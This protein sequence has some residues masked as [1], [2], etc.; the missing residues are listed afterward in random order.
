MKKFLSCLLIVS[1]VLSMNLGLFAEKAKGSLSLSGE[2]VIRSEN[3]EFI[4]EFLSGALN[5]IAAQ[6]KDPIVGSVGGEWAVIALNRGGRKDENWNN[7]Y[8][9]NLKSYLDVNSNNKLT[10]CERMILA[11]TSTGKDASKFYG[12]DLVSELKNKN[13]SGGYALEEQGINAVIY[14]L[15]ALDSGNYLPNEEG[16]ALRNWCI[17]YLLQHEKING[18]WDYTGE[19]TGDADVDMTGIA[20]QALAPYYKNNGYRFAEVKSSVETA[21]TALQEAQREDGSFGYGEWP[22]SSDSAAS[23]VMAL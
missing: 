5:Y 14:A 6:V 4:E 13:S 3:S 12:Y 7:I 21:V 9:N 18:G 2:S 15:I 22:S 8:L 1:L 23:V 16:R 10:D 20:L 19:V 17:D 11:L